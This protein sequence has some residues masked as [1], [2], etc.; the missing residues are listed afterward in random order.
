MSFHVG[1][2]LGDYKIT[3]LIGAG[4]MGRVFQVEHR[5]TKRREAV[6][7]LSAELATPI[8]I[9]RFEREIAVQARLSHPNIATVHN[10]FSWKGCLVMVTEFL[11]GQTV[12]K[13]LSQGRLPIETGIDY[14]RQILSALSYAHERGIVHRDVTPANL[15][16]TPAGVVKLTDFGVSKSFGDIQL[17]NCGDIVGSL[18][19]M[20]PE[21]ARGGS[22]PDRRSDLYSVG[23]ILYEILTGKKPFGGERKFAS[24]VTDSE[25]DPPPPT[26]VAAFL[27]VQWNEV[28]GK[29]LMRD[30][31]LRY[32]TA[33]EFLQSVNRTA[34]A[35]GIRPTAGVLSRWHFW[36]AGAGVA[37][38]VVLLAGIHEFGQIPAPPPISFHIAPPE[39]IARP[40][41]APVIEAKA[42]QARRSAMPHAAR[43]SI[44]NR[45]EHLSMAQPQVVNTDQGLHLPIAAAAASKVV[46]PSATVL[47]PQPT[48][49]EPEQKVPTPID[50][51]EAAP[52]ESKP[53]R[54]HGF[55]NKLNP[56]KRKADP[57]AADPP[58][59]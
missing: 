26:D 9:Q 29:A 39:T 1:E 2:D 31:A 45:S 28:V 53:A 37:A 8:Q 4:S 34:R 30:R 59:Q 21:Q 58:T 10:A 55:W 47:A 38:A 20:A 52:V 18:E 23:V 56:F 41:A 24:M 49:M 27:P 19:Y 15:I 11:E 25:S 13:L 44:L 48:M 57:P 32:S 14:I 5:L 33:S 42:V 7:V 36:V 46:M 40:A 50:D 6:K 35:T 12:E 17:T 3:A 22:H 51:A 54:K 16:V 43:S